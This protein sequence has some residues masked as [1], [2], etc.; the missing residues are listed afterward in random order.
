MS[1]ILKDGD[2]ICLFCGESEE[3]FYDE[4]TPYW[5]CNCK[6]TVRDR[7]ITEEIRKLEQMRP[8]KQFE[9][10]SKKVLYKKEE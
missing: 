3:Q 8:K 5:E 10:L 4:Y 6:D 9:I 2:N 7:Q 1:K